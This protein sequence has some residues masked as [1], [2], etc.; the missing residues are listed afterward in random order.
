LILF[1]K[2]TPPGVHGRSIVISTAIISKQR[3]IRKRCVS[4]IFAHFDIRVHYFLSF[5][6][7]GGAKLADDYRR[8]A[9]PRLR[10]GSPGK[11]ELKMRKS[12]MVLF[13]LFFVAFLSRCGGAGP[14]GRLHSFDLKEIAAGNSDIAVLGRGQGFRGRV[15]KIKPVDGNQRVVIWEAGS[16][17]D[18]SRPDTLSAKCGMKMDTAE[19]STSSSMPAG[20]AIVRPM[21][22][23]GTIP[24]PSVSG[25]G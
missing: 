25:P 3:V 1:F 4:V 14:K 17:I 8:P 24:R 15:L 11:G 20:E 6:T 22:K 21:S 19:S 12:G 5:M 7:M 16:A 18:W 23:L 2:A 10:H 9:H 13:S